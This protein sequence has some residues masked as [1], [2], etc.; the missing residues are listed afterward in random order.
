MNA[1]TVSLDWTFWI[2]ALPKF[3]LYVALLLAVGACGARAL[4]GTSAGRR[5]E[6]L[7][8][9]VSNSDSQTTARRLEWVLL[10][11]TCAMV[12]LIASRSITHTLAAF[13]M[14]DAVRWESF[15]LIVWESAWGS[16][17]RVHMGLGV[18]LVV[19]ALTVF[20]APRGGWALA[21]GLA[22]AACYALPL[23]GHAAGEAVRVVL[24]GSHL[25]GAGLWLG[26]LTAL[27]IA[28]RDA[29]RRARTLGRFAPMAVA[30]AAV[31]LLT[32]GVMA[33]TYLTAPSDLWSHGYGQT[34]AVKLGLVAGA[35]ACGALNWRQHRPT[36]SGPCVRRPSLVALELLLALL[37]VGAT[38]MLTEMPHPD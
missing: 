1:S 23:I 28:E 12:I 9:A 6:N 10:A 24:H 22:L 27:W 4:L 14:P 13:G 17:W 31:I 2:E 33:W 30:S 3:G 16:A 36:A 8:E 29:Q 34:L 15:E 7:G 26:T 35:L 20:W 38:A 5:D 37:V 21:G 18:A 32:G 25:V 19:A 11:S